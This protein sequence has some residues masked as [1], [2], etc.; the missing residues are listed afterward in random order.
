MDPGR[1]R[2]QRMK[3][4]VLGDQGIDPSGEVGHRRR[5]SWRGSGAV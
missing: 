3:G 4:E 2:V 5:L 1:S